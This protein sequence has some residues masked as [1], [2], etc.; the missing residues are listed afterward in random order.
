MLRAQPLELTS[1]LS[2]LPWRLRW[3]LVV[4]ESL[5]SECTARQTF[6]VLTL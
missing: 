2:K 3:L 5:N 4:P 1:W 6:G